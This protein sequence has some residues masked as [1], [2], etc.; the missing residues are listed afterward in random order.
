MKLYKF[1]LSTCLVGS[2]AALVSC[3]DD[4][5]FVEA[6]KEA[7]IL[8]GETSCLRIVGNSGV[9]WKS[10]MEGNVITVKINPEL[11]P[12][13]ELS[14]VTAKFFISKGATVTPDP[15]IPQNFY[16]D[17]GIQYTVTSEDGKASNTY[18]VTYS[19]TAVPEYGNGFTRG[20]QVAY[21]TFPELGY[22]GT[23]GLF[24]GV[25]DSRLYGD[26]NGYVAYCGPDHIVLLARQYSDPHFDNAALNIQDASL[27]CRVF[28]AEDLSFVGNLNLG[29]I[30]M[31]NIRAITSDMSGVLVAAVNTGS[32]CDLYTWSAY[33]AT[34]SLLGTVEGT[35]CSAVDGSNYL[36]VMG[37]FAEEANITGNAFRDPDGKHYMIHVENGQIND[38]QIITTGVPASDG[39]GFQMMSPILP[40]LN[41]SYILGDTDPT[42]KDSNGNNSI[43]ITANTYGGKTKVIMP[44]VLQNMWQQWW[45]GAGSML[46][47]TGARRPYVN[48]MLINGK[49]Y[50]LISN[51][52]NWWW[53]FDIAELDDMSTRV[54]GTTWADS[55]NAGWS[56]GSC[57]DWYWDAERGEGHVIYYAERIGMCVYRLTCF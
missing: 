56:F 42:I 11:D 6:G 13:E 32:S 52:T 37:S 39:N 19:P 43:R 2:S 25:T 15:S 4:D 30:D 29:S 53:H 20:T 41:S 27:A 35:L 5:I 36:S 34:P 23:K 45:V 24:D 9:T 40:T 10:D 3:N 51:G 50:A 16:V 1:I 7:I 57:A 47:R 14:D 17:G 26:L 31:K 49:H 55:V 12:V 22:P 18:T 54:T 8:D 33:N 21:K 48:D 46:L 44:N 38:T 28:N